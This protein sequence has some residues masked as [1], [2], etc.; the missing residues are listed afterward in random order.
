MARSEW[1]DHGRLII[2][3]NPV[4]RTSKNIGVIE[5]KMKKLKFSTS[6]SPRHGHCILT[7]QKARALYLSFSLHP[8]FSSLLSLLSPL[9][10]ERE[11]KTKEEEGGR[12][13]KRKRREA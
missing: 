6:P 12:R 8:P 11:I 7:P 1:M 10:G 2:P 13:E 4:K 5:Q 9:S 3:F